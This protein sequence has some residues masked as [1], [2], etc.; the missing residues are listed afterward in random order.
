MTSEPHSTTGLRDPAG[1]RAPAGVRP[2]GPVPAG[3]R[4]DADSFAAQMPWL[5]PRQRE[6]VVRLYVTERVLLARQAER[7]AAEAA[8]RARAEAD[9][10]CAELRRRMCLAVAVLLGGLVTAVCALVM[11]HL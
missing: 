2:S 5:T 3:A 4:A 9:A 8:A 11:H 1:N 10:A 7:G 6:R